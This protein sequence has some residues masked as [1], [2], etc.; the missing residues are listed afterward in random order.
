MSEAYGF[1]VLAFFLIIGIVGDPDMLSV[2]C[3]ALQVPN[4]NPWQHSTGNLGLT[5][6]IMATSA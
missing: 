1:L 5:V 2:R 4:P 6:T 3:S